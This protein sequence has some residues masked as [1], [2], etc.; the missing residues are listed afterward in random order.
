MTRVAIVGYGYAGRVFHAPLVQLVPGLDLY[1][2]STRDPERRSAAQ[3]A[4]PGCKLFA[5]LDDLL[6]DGRV[7]LAVLATPHYTHRDL[8][9]EAM[10]AGCHVVVDKVMCINA[11]EAVDMIDARDRNGVLLSIFHNRRWDWDY[12]TV[13][14]VIQQG[15]IGE[16]YLFEAG[17]MA[18]RPPHGWRAVKAQSGGILYDWPAHFLDQALQ[19][20]PAPPQRVSCEIVDRGHWGSDIGNYARMTIR[21]ANGVL[22][23]IEIGNLSAAPKPR[24][25]VVGDSGGLV[26]TGLDPQEAALR[27]GDIEAAREDPAD[28][29]RLF[30]PQDGSVEERIVESI[31]GSWT[32]YYQN[33]ADV[34]ANGAD[35][36]VTPEQV[37]R[38]MQVYDAA[39][40]SAR[41]GE[42][43]HIPVQ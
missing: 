40:L 42:T 11:R 29:A 24:W 10:N 33:I 39:M 5:S 34:L 3:S 8:A 9:I 18:H 38:V 25:Y 1:A 32:S 2:I 28:R 4:H 37:Y 23:Q 31:R 43:V 30:T 15:W 16:P 7:E 21:F 27:A 12:L 20:V 17:I 19:L 36:A 22:Y 35:L 6:D 26:K 41:R 14:H 13:K